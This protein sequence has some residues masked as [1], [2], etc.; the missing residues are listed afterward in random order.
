MRL[1]ATPV[2]DVVRSRRAAA[3]AWYGTR[4]HV[5]LEV[6]SAC[7][8]ARRWCLCQALGP[9]CGAGVGYRHGGWGEV[10]RGYRGEGRETHR[11]DE[12]YR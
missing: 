4:M 12:S 11:V 10:L 7:M 8:C 6:V 1:P 3:G 9:G 5:C 2:G